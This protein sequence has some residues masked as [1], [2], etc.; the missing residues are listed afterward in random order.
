[1]QLGWRT[2]CR[3]GCGAVRFRQEEQIIRGTKVAGFF[4]LP[5]LPR[6][7]LRVELRDLGVR[8]V[9]WP[10]RPLG[11]SRHGKRG[12]NKHLRV[13]SGSFF[14]SPV[15]AGSKGRRCAVPGTGRAETWACRGCPWVNWCGDERDEGHL[16]TGTPRRRWRGRWERTPSPNPA[17]APRSAGWPCRRR[18]RGW[19]PWSARSRGCRPGLCRGGTVR[20]VTAWFRA[21]RCRCRVCEVCW[22]APFSA[23]NKVFLARC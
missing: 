16:E 12:A 8:G 7:E 20:V 14:V 9:C 6:P 21:T 5:F 2:L 11:A 1:M 23:W 19:G 17:L 15:S 22:W 18:P 13:F 10:G 4:P 3:Q